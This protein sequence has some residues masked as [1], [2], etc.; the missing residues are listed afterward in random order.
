MIK[1]LITKPVGFALTV[2]RDYKILRSIAKFYYV[3]NDKNKIL[4]YRFL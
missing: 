1:T 4:K 2:G 3:K